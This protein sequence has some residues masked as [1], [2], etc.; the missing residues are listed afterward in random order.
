M[1]LVFPVLYILVKFP[2]GALNT[3]GA[4]KFSDFRPIS[5]YMWETIQDRAIV[6]CAV[7]NCDIYDDLE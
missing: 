7:S 5:G 4:Y 1:I 3:G 2:T 6:I